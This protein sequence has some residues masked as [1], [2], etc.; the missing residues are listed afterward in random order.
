MVFDHIFAENAPILFKNYNFL[1]FKN[2]PFWLF[3]GVLEV[4][5]KFQNKF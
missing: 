5:L 3:S 4:K 1:F 2:Q